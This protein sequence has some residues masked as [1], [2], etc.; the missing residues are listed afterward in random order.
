MAVT[1]TES[2]GV[3]SVTGTGALTGYDNI[4]VKRI[5]AIVSGAGDVVVK[6]GGTSGV[7]IIDESVATKLVDGSTI[8]L[9]S[10]A[11][12]QHIKDLF[13]TTLANVALVIYFE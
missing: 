1:I 13:V 10:F 6:A 7:V 11:K 3:I 2:R 9:I 12:P 5:D 8:P 4:R